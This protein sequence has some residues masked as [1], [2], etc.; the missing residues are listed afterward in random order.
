[1]KLRLTVDGKI[2]EVEVEIIEQDRQ[3]RGQAPSA[4]HSPAVVP[5]ATGTPVASPP[6]SSGAESADESKVFRSPISG[7]V[8]RLPVQVGHTVKSNEVL[9]VLEAM[10]ME[11]VITSQFGGKISKINAS[12]GDSVTVKQVLVEFE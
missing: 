8:V 5:V 2:Y 7:V 11:T 10:K 9:M 1:L 12:V 4:M 3:H 6:P